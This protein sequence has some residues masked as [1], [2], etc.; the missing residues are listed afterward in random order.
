MKA[1]CEERGNKLIIGNE[2]YSTKTCTNCGS[3]NRPNDRDYKCSNCKLE[4]HRDLNG[5]RNILL[6]NN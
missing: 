1:K 3:L 5:A 4:I 6:M 2:C